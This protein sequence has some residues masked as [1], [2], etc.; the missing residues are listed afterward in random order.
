M[1]EI[2]SVHVSQIGFG[3]AWNAAKRIS[4]AIGELGSPANL[5]FEVGRDKSFYINGTRLMSK[6]DHE[7]QSL[8]RTETTTSILKGT[9]NLDWFQQIQERNQNSDIWNLHWLPGYPNKSLFKLL[10]EKNVVWTLH[11]SNP[12]TGICHYSEA[13]QNFMND[14]GHCPQIL[15]IMNSVP[16]KVLNRKLQMF[17]QAK[18]LVFVAPSLWIMREFQ[19]STAGQYA[20]IVNIPNPIPSIFFMNNPKEKSNTVTITVLGNDYSKSKNSQLGALAI[21]RFIE[22][23]TYVKV[24]IQIIGEA[25]SFL[26]FNEQVCLPPGSSQSDLAEFLKKSDVFIYTS[27]FDNL[28]NLV[29]E[30]QA[31]GN[32]VLAI[33]AGGVRECFLDKETGFEVEPNHESIS[34]A[35]QVLLQDP[36]SMPIMS[37]RATQNVEDKF[38]SREVGKK[39]LG[40]YGDLLS[41]KQNI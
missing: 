3:G 31:A 4:R 1:K 6:I 11:D 37:R 19:E 36:E 29:L 40:L 39:Y 38:S 22:L 33:A 10:N 18:N 25:Y 13:C 17:K 9:A 32:I 41:R 35:L 27:I 20:D 30:A 24:R 34:N 7:I 15:K 14:C 28:P 26:N 12:Y 16:R 5:E 2:S 23:N 21:K 8:S